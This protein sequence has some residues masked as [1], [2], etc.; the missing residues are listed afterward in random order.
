MT[1]QA[2]SK[3]IVYL[4]RL[5]AV[6]GLAIICFT[7]SSVEHLTDLLTVKPFFIF[8]GVMLIKYTI[9]IHRVLTPSIVHR[10]Y[11]AIAVPV[12]IIPIFW[13]L[14][15]N[16]TT[17]VLK[18]AIAVVYFLAVGVTYKI[19]LAKSGRILF[20]EEIVE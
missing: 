8:Y 15:T 5:T 13:F 6:C 9:D 18:A 17:T 20:G 11:S 10:Y 16:G 19:L 7:V 14:G 12:G 3:L 1:S 4:S 2:L